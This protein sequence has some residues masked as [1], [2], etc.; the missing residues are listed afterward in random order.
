M[1]TLYQTLEHLALELPFGDDIS[2][3]TRALFLIYSDEIWYLPWRD[4][5]AAHDK[6]SERRTVQNLIALVLREM[7]R[8]AQAI[9]VE[10]GRGG[11]FEQS[12]CPVLP[13]EDAAIVQRAWDALSTAPAWTA[14][15]SQIDKLATRYAED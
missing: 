9:L 11:I 15:E 14:F 7:Q 12:G 5:Q 4:R 3:T 1:R 6:L 13:P 2:Q 8:H 10:Q